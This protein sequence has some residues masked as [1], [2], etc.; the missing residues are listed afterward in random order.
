MKNSL[1]RAFGGVVLLVGSSVIQLANFVAG[2]M[3]PNKLILHQR[4]PVVD[5]KSEHT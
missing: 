4:S 2:R 1:N 5:V 3:Y